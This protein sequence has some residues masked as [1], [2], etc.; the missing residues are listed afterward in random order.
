MADRQMD[1]L[2]YL[3]QGLGSAFEYNPMM[4]P[5]PP[6]GGGFVQGG[7]NG[8]GSV[9]EIDPAQ[10]NARLQ[11]LRIQ[12]QA[13]A[14]S[15]QQSQPSN[16][17]PTSPDKHHPIGY[18]PIHELLQPLQYPY[19][20]YPSVTSLGPDDSVSRFQKM[21]RPSRKP[22]PESSGQSLS[23]RRG[24]TNIDR[25]DEG[26]DYEP[27]E[28]DHLDR[29]ETGSYGSHGGVTRDSPGPD[30]LEFDQITL[31][32]TSVWTSGT[33]AGNMY[34]MRDR[35]IQTAEEREQAKHSEL[36]RQLDETAKLAAALA[37]LETA[38]QQLRGLQA[39]LIA[40]RV[41]RSQIE[42][43]AET[44]MNHMHDCSRELGAAV[45]ALRRAKEEGKRTD[46]ERRR[47]Q[48]AFDETVNRLHIYHEALEVRK[49][50]EKGRE[51]GRN[52]A[53]AEIAQWL[54]SEPPIPGM[55]P[56]QSIPPAVLH[57]TPMMQP[58]QQLY[59]QVQVQ[60]MY[61]PQQVQPQS[62]QSPP[63]QDTQP[64][65]APMQMPMTSPP[66]QNQSYAPHPI[67][68][69]SQ[70]PQ[71][72]IEQMFH[73][74]QV[75]QSL[76]AQQA[77]QAEQLQQSQS[78]QQPRQ[79]SQTPQPMTSQQKGPTPPP[80]ISQQTGQTQM[81]MMPQHTAQTQQD[82]MPMTNQHTGQTQMPTM[83]QQ[84]GQ[85][86]PP[87]MAPPTGQPQMT[88]NGHPQMAQLNGQAQM[89]QFV[90]GMMA[91]NQQPQ[92]QQHPQML[93]V[94]MAVELVPAVQTFQPVMM[95]TNPAMI[96]LP[97]TTQT[98]YTALPQPSRPPTVGH[99]TPHQPPLQMPQAQSTYT[100]PVRTQPPASVRSKSQR[101]PPTVAS[102]TLSV[103]RVE[104]VSRPGAA[105]SYLEKMEQ[106]SMVQSLLRNAPSRTIHTDRFP[107]DDSDHFRSSSE[108]PLP[109]PMA[110]VPPPPSNRHAP[111][112]TPSRGPGKSKAPSVNSRVPGRRYSLIEGLHAHAHSQPQT[113]DGDRYP[114][115]AKGAGT[116]VGPSRH[117]SAESLDPV[118]V[119]LPASAMQT[120]AT[121][122]RNDYHTGPNHRNHGPPS[123]VPSQSGHSRTRSRVA[124]ALRSDE[125][126]GPEMMS[127]PESQ[128]P[129]SQ[130]TH[131]TQQTQQNQQFQQ[132]QHGQPF[133]H[134][135]QGQM[136]RNT[137]H[138]QGRRNYAPSM[139]PSRPRPQVVLP[140]R[141]GA[142]GGKAAS[143]HP[144][145]GY[146][147][148]DL[149][150][151]Y[152]RDLA[153]RLTDQLPEP[154]NAY[155]V[156]NSHPMYVPPGM[157]PAAVGGGVEDV[158]GPR[159]SALGL[160]GIESR[161]QSVKAPTSNS[162]SQLAT[163]RT[164]PMSLPS[165]PHDQS[166]APTERS[167]NQGG[168]AQSYFSQNVQPH[169]I[170]LPISR[171]PTQPSRP[172]TSQEQFR[173]ISK[174]PTSQGNFQIGMRQLQPHEYPLPPSK[175][176]TQA[177]SRPPTSQ[178]NH[179]RRFEPHEVPLPR[180]RAATNYT[181]VSPPES[182]VSP[183]EAR[184]M[185]MGGNTLDHAVGKPLPDSRPTTYFGTGV[186][187]LVSPTGTAKSKGNIRRK[188]V[189]EPFSRASSRAATRARQSTHA[190]TLATI[191]DMTEESG[192]EG[193]S[194]VSR[195]Q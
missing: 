75:Q 24:G 74:Q 166:R 64:Q 90:N 193:R 85:I 150:A 41:A 194:R 96:P 120:P 1:Q 28:H 92:T 13:S 125:E 88:Q 171:A 91:L 181:G 56:L 106:D 191:E 40:E 52:A 195:V 6:R 105:E 36:H 151:M 136:Q 11:A 97:M 133:P 83:Q 60:H 53:L 127:P 14:E 32:P 33:L 43:E 18:Q 187:D 147:R 61:H 34:T 55:A 71:Q 21:Y 62:Y 189:P 77:Q 186:M 67:S 157:A 115:F 76:H 109:D 58:A 78:P 128:V 27:A 86:P 111:S 39:T 132:N 69:T 154:K 31:N 192:A 184:G 47:M 139:P 129:Q 44:S 99:R 63:M 30:A 145:A 130:Y 48:R 45:R 110:R 160:E 137:M 141:L 93:A 167:Q 117:P 165:K 72:S 173:S 46:E 10:L 82:R 142:P 153:A 188:P 57:Q 161:A 112:V 178:G 116:S 163:A 9:G 131:H 124:G 176:P 146:R 155:E 170:P 134:H 42:Q 114:M 177:A 182:G 149:G 190:P 73:A 172:G 104:S 81:P 66:Q 23:G 65:Q 12:A 107:S 68:P 29:G 144:H 16:P 89:P 51:E 126:L 169:E 164:A 175:A 174:P 185:S 35:L 119:P 101:A 152:G 148:P 70:M 179:G 94:P 4:Y 80:M 84:V 98:T 140:Q 2:Q 159:H 26:V 38:E 118:N 156:P 59:P 19:N 20:K 168:A 162:V 143:D 180:S 79:G 17:S 50:S 25:G 123:H 22:V 49:A 103:P 122:Y 37:K 108:K 54:S 100:T 158:Q 183:E 135:P 8:A 87:Q 113:V 3:S 102:N 5:N 121:Q 7:K 138:P 95:S 15:L